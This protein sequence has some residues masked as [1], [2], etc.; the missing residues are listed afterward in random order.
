MQNLPELEDAERQHAEMYPTE[1][2]ISFVGTVVVPHESNIPKVEYQTDGANSF[3]D[4]DYVT[5]DSQDSLYILLCRLTD[6]VGHLVADCQQGGWRETTFVCLDENG[7]I[8][9]A[10]SNFNPNPVRQLCDTPKEIDAPE[11]S[12]RQVL[13]NVWEV[14]GQ[15][16]EPLIEAG[17]IVYLISCRLADVPCGVLATVQTGTDLE[18]EI[19]PTFLSYVK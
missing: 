14:G 16:D 6:S 4:G 13:E 1:R 5:I 3:L 12:P 9:K 2:Y 17:E 19:A 15:G 18:Y 7:D 8:V 10:K 11:R